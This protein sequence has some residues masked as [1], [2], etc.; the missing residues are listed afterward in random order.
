VPGFAEPG[1]STSS[2]RSAHN[3]ALWRTLE[4]I[5]DDFQERTFQAFWLV[6]MED[7]PAREVAQQ[8]GMTLAAVHQAKYRVAQRLREELGDGE[9]DLE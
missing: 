1:S 9:T 2:E 5:R 8:L 6:A 3:I 4:T 7:K